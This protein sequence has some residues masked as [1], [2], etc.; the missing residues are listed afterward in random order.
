MTLKP[1]GMDEEIKRIIESCLPQQ[2]GDALKKR[3][4]KADSDAAELECV[5]QQRDDAQEERTRFYRQLQAQE[6]LDKRT[7]AIEKREAE[8]TAREVRI[9]L[10]D[11]RV[12]LTNEK[13]QAIFQ[14]AETVFRFG[15][16]KILTS[17]SRSFPMN[18]SPS[19][20]W[21]SMQSETRSASQEVQ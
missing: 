4:L 17:E 2:V 5:K 18:P 8:V 9:E 12:A 11:Q 19:G 1:T 7:A 10:A 20:Q 15:P 6:V 13:C 14:L 3:L 21:P 16:T